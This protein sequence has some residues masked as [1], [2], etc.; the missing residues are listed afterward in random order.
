MAQSYFSLVTNTGK[1]KLAESAAGGDAVTITHFAI[2]DGGG[3]ETNP[4]ASAE[5]LVNEVWRTPVES[6]E[7]DP[8]N[9]SAVLVKAIIPVNEGGWWMREFGIFDVE[10][11]MIAVAKPVSQYKPTALEGQLEDILYE[12]QIII[13]ENADVTLLVDPSV[14]LASRAWVAARKIPMGQFMRPGY[15]SVEGFVNDPPA[16]P[17]QGLTWIVGTAPTGVF[18][19]HENE[20]AEWAGNGWSFVVPSPWFHAGMA[21]RTDWRWDHTLPEP[22][23]VKWLAD[24]DVAGPIILNSTL[25]LNPVFPEVETPDGRLSLTDNGNGTLSLDA[26]Q[27]WIWRGHRRIASDKFD[28]T[29]RTYA[30]VADKT[31]H[32][33]W[34]AP[35]TGTAMPEATY[36]NGRFELVDMTEADPPEEDADHD[37]TFD[38]MLIARIMTNGANVPTVTALANKAALRAVGTVTFSISAMDPFEDSTRPED[39]Q[40]TT[41][42]LNWARKGFFKFVGSTDWWVQFST[43]PEENE[44]MNLGTSDRNRYSGVVFLQRLG[45]KGPSGAWVRFVAEA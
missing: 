29:E 43:A 35:G 1:I 8:D 23:W 42:T 33:R 45:P 4:T 11:D 34:H 24:G 40:N 10:G 18:V 22:A 38:R 28:A 27:S 3:A 39:I 2:G 26:G 32:L 44:E 17:T 5:A 20:L 30:T 12:F 41:V 14:L 6:V 25:R 19:D 36:P 9:P 13:G 15:R 31:Y 21:D 7:T 37:T 16:N